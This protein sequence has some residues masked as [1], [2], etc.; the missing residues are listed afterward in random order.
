MAGAAS[1]TTNPILLGLIGCVVA[2]VVAARR[3]DAPW[4]RSL[5]VFLRLG[6]VVIVLRV[7]L[8]IVFGDRLP[9]HV[10]FTLPHVPLPVW[11]AGVSIGGPVTAESVLGAVVQGLQ[12]M[13]G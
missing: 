6:L 10:L 3:T 5:V 12:V 1:R 11:A 8:V 2:Y 4:A 13:V 7:V 9:G